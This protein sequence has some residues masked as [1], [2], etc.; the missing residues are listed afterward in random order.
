MLEAVAD[1]TANEC[2]AGWSELHAACFFIGGKGYQC[3]LGLTP[4]QQARL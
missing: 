3:R 1:E 2:R 4:E